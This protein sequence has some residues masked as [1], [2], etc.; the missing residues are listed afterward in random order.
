MISQSL[1]LWGDLMSSGAGIKIEAG[2]ACCGLE[3]MVDGVSTL[4]GA[5]RRRLAVATQ[6]ATRGLL[7]QHKV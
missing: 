5:V 7:L 2:K 1:V 3:Q 4:N 6:P